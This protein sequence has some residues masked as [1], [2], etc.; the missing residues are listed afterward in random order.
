M[1]ATHQ[2]N[3]QQLINYLNVTRQAVLDTLTGLSEA[4]LATPLDASGRTVR[5][6]L[7]EW[8][9]VSAEPH[10]RIDVKPDDL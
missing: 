8:V 9:A 4:Q 10:A 5:I 1:L 2:A 7:S 3:K 6:S